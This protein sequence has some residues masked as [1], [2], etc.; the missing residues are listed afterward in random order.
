MAEAALKLKK[1]AGKPAAKPGKPVAPAK[2][3][4]AGKPGVAG[5]TGSSPAGRVAA[6][7]AAKKAVPATKPGVAGKPEKPAAASK[8]KEEEEKAPESLDLPHKVVRVF[9]RRG[10]SPRVSEG[11][12]SY[13][14]DLHRQI[15]TQ[16]VSNAT[17]RMVLDGRITILPRDMTKA[18]GMHKTRIY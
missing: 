6:A 14:N 11:T 3:S 1:T 9:Y 16:F 18:L 7:L 4:V 5:K 12:Y 15:L 2:S 17:R 13:M 8:K 10:G